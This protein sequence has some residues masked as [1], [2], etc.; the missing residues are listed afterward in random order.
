MKSNIFYLILT[1][2]I[3]FISKPP[4]KL[5]RNHLGRMDCKTGYAIEFADGYGLNYIN[6]VFFSQEDFDKFFVKRATPRDIMDIRNAE[7]KAEVIK[8]YGYEYVV[9][10]LENVKILD[11]K[12]VKSKITKKSC[13]YRLIEFD[14]AQNLQARVVLV[15]DHTTH[16]KV[17]LGVPREKLTETCMGAIA[18]TFGM[19]SKD[20]APKMES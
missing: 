2:Y 6:G 10:G 8:H 18:W 3:A 9:S 20:Y 14:I 11:T 15:E 4:V 7:Q 16:K 12:I 17:F 19:E 13:E 5:I 1:D